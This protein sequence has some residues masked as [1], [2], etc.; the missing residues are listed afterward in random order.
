MYQQEAKEH[1]IET[2]EAGEIVYH[3]EA[4]RAC[5]SRLACMNTL[6]GKIVIPPNRRGPEPAV[7]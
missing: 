1:T 4:F 5:V 3:Q 2:E 7:G 6:R